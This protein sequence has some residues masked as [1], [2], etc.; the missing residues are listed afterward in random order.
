MAAELAHDAVAVAF[1]VLLDRR[2]DVT[3]KSPGVH[4]PDA[5]PHA[6]VGGLAQPLCPDG[7]FADVVHAAGIA[8]KTVFD[9]GDVDIQDIARLEHALPWNPVADLVVDRGADRFWKGLIA[10]RS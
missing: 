1:G 6:L 5:E 10:G 2:P 4:R 3:K 7:R 9:H 8:V